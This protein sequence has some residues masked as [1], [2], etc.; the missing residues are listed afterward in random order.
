MG[1]VYWTRFRFF[2]NYYLNRNF[3]HL[4]KNVKNELYSKSE[5]MFYQINLE[6][7]E[8][9]EKWRTS[10]AENALSDEDIL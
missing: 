9:E 3:Y 7:F 5:I 4:T 2:T 10:K 6:C 1:L 8:Y